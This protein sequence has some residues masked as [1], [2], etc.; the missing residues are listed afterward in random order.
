[1]DIGDP[2]TVA[3]LL[4]GFPPNKF[5]ITKQ[6]VIATPRESGGRFVDLKVTELKGGQRLFEVAWRGGH[7]R[8]ATEAEAVALFLEKLKAIQ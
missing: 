8:V 6:M 5:E 7:K 2:K 1:M 4:L 3:A